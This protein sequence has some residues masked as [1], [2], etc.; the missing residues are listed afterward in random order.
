MLRKLDELH[1][2]AVHASD[3]II[4]HIKDFYFDDHAWV[5]RYLVVETGSWLSSRKVLISPIGTGSP[6]WQER[7]LPASISMDQVSNSPAIDTEKP[8]SRQH[9]GEF[10]EH[11]LYP[12][13][14]VGPGLWGAGNYP[15]PYLMAMPEFVST[16]AVI[17]PVI[18]QVEPLADA[19]PVDASVVRHVD[20]D[21]RSCNVLAGYRIHATDG[22]VGHVQGFLF[23]QGTWEIRYLIVYTSNWWLGHQMLIA[24][25]SIQDVSWFDGIVSIKLTREQVKN[26]PR[27]D[28]E[29]PLDQVLEPVA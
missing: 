5:I 4:G 11:Y 29:M 7:T 22:E 14:W 16:P 8:V 21:L 3:G 26:A 1:D 15:S 12:L 28:P 17:L 23:D 20:P 25:Q 9:E 13:Y 19:A 24:P 18:D 27:Y 10:L 6:D 2:F